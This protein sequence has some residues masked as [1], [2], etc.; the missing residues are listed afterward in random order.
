MIPY[1]AC[2]LHLTASCSRVSENHCTYPEEPSPF[3]YPE[4]ACTSPVTCEAGEFT[5]EA[6]SPIALANGSAFL[7]PKSRKLTCF[8]RFCTGIQE[9]QPLA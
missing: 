2:F 6:Y 1:V 5:V 3:A 4:S 7:A 9:R 8:A